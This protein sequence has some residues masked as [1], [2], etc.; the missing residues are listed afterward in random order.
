MTEKIL[1]K[2]WIYLPLALILALYVRGNEIILNTPFMFNIIV[3]LF[4]FLLLLFCCYRYN[5][6]EN[7]QG[8]KIKKRDTTDVIIELVGCFILSFFCF[9][10][11]KLLF[12]FYLESKAKDK[13][14]LEMNLPID[15]YIKGRRDMMHF[16]YKDLKYS[17]RYT[18]PDKLSKEE[19][20]NHYCIQIKYSKSE[21]NTAVVKG[22]NIVP[23]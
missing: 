10:T 18:N 19:I 12:N 21:F 2:R 8:H 9:I 13:A 7:F 17:F 16:Y 23:K 1:S 3:F 11:I 5:K 22:Y 14:I 20:L 15:N 6:T 4:C